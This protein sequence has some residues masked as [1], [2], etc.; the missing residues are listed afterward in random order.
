M[1]PLRQAV[2]DGELDA[3]PTLLAENVTFV[4]PVAYAPYHGRG[5]VS[6]I[7][8]GVSAVF[9]DFHYLNEIGRTD[10]R[11]FA[12][13]FKA[14]V[15]DREIH[16]CDILHHDDDGLIDEF[17]VMV[18]PLSA[19]KELARAMEEQFAAIEREAGLV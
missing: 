2:E 12:L 17:M 3:I 4:S 15:G 5:M 7:L 1:H 8:R 10:G 16:G 19:A 14:V 18:R 6:A 9:E 13:I 11:D